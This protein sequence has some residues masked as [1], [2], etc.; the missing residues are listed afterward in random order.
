MAREAP[1][2]PA[3]E[4]GGRTWSYGELGQAS[5]ALARVLR[6][7][8]VDR[9]SV[10]AVTGS[11]SFGLVTG[12][13]AVLAARGVMLPVAADLPQRRKLLML[14]EAGASHLVQV[15]RSTP[16]DGWIR[17]IGPVSVIRVDGWSGAA[18]DAAALQDPGP[19]APPGPEDPACIFF[20]SGTSGTPKGVLGVHQGIG[21]FLDWQR[22]T[23]AIAPGDRC[24][25]LTNISFD[26]VL[27][28]VFLPLTSGATLCLPPAELP[29]DRVLDWLAEERIGVVHVVPSLAAAWLDHAPAGTTLPA[30]R[31]VFLAG[32]QLTDTL[33]RRW[34]A[35]L[36][37]ACEVV[38][39]YGPTE[40]TM[41]KCFY[42][43]PAEVPSGM[44]PVGRP[45]PESQALVLSGDLRLCG[46]NEPGE[47]VLRT[48]F[49]TRGYINAA[50]EQSAHFI[51][52][53]F[54]GEP[55]DLL[56]RTG[57]LG[58]YRPDGTLL[59]LGRLDEQIKIRG[60]RIEPEEVTAVLAGHAGVRACAVV[61]RELGNQP[62]ALVAYVARH[63][64]DLGAAE[65]RA[66]LAERLPAALVPSAF[67]FL[68]RLPLTA[69]G[70]LDRRGLPAPDVPDGRDEGNHTA[71][72]T[73][74]EEAVAGMWSEVLGVERIGVH[75]DFF[76]LG[77]HSLMA[78]RIV[79]RLRS[80]MGIELPLRTLFE[81][82]TVAGLAAV[83]S[84]RLADGSDR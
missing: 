31:H 47:I 41:V 24:G 23:F 76:A 18:L 14:R 79:A 75:D 61:G 50:G 1:A 4:Q 9:G 55:G 2:R 73:P 62:V 6:A 8:G 42:R 48:P 49:M 20:T 71:P 32:E 21:H 38:N 44:L 53:P 83:V 60:V 5:D 51:P 56:Y 69:N 19:L 57:D 81:A 34:R 43:V 58:R 35:V 65:L 25:Q 84:G 17:D 10:V 22:T 72:R 40:T 46:I 36:T 26:V 39:L 33:V 66:Y 80:A 7:R 63:D 13:L 15:G 82:P 12:M 27:R 54:S 16:E 68:E 3:I 37:P 77:G 70:K 74:L 28:D 52:S 78:T 45:L 64:D 30:L 59:V 29:P 11:S 67:V